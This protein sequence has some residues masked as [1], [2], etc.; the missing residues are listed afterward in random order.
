MRCLCNEETAKERRA[1][2]SGALWRLLRAS[3]GLLGLL[4]WFVGMRAFAWLWLA[5]FR[6]G[7]SRVWLDCFV[8]LVACGTVG[9]APRNAWQSCER[10]AFPLCVG[11]SVAGLVLGLG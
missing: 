2:A 4:R 3:G 1:G 5:M 6:F 10:G 8:W 7:I 9:G 11:R